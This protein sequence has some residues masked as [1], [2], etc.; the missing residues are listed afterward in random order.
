MD[1]WHLA[2]AEEGQAQYYITCD[3]LLLTWSERIGL[4][5]CVIN[6]TDFVRRGMR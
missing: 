1:A 4:A 2:S 6:P 5:L 3:D